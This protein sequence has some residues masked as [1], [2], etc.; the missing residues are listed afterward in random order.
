LPTLTV[1]DTSWPNSGVKAMRQIE[2]HNMSLIQSRYGIPSHCGLLAVVFSA[3]LVFFFNPSMASAQEVKQI[4][5]TEK[6]MQGFIAVFEDVAQLYDRAS[7]DKP[8]PKLEAQAEALVKQNGFANLAE[9]DDVSMN[10]ALIM[11]GIDPQTKKFTEPPEQIKQQID[12]VKSDKSIPEA[13]KKEDLEQLGTALKS[14][15]PIQF[16]DNI[17]LVRK[18]YDRLTELM[19]GQG[20]AD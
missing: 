11:A 16:K 7:Q 14:A 17:S 18:Y 9:Y 20:P 2:A 19:Q 6:H 8:D 12:A 3:L 10:I 15:K 4:R 13:E 1:I 5:L